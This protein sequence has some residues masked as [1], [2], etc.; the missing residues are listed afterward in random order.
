MVEVADIRDPESFRAWLEETRQPQQ[1][2]VAL[3]ARAAAR[4]L[5][6]VWAILAR[7]NTFS[8]LPFVRANLIANVAGL[9]PTGMMTDS[10]YVSALRGS[11]YAAYAVADDAA[12]A[13][14][15]DAVFPAR[16]AAYA[17]F[18][19]TAADAAFAATAAFAY[20]D[21]AA[22]AAAWSVLRSDCM[23]V[24]EGT[25]LRS[26]PLFPDRASAPL[27]IAWREVQRHYGSDAAWHF[28][29]DWYRRFLTGRRQNWPLLLE[30][31]LQDND[32]WHGSDAEINA[33]IAEIAARFEAEDPVD[34]PQGDSIATALPQAIENSYNAERIVERDDRFDVEP[35]TEIDA[36]AFQLGLQR[37]TIL[38]EDIA[39][40]VADRP[41][42]LSALPEAIR[43]LVKALAETGEFPYLVYHAL[44]RSA[45]RIKIMCQ[46]EELP[47]NDYAVEDFR[48]Q[49]RSIALDILANDPQVKKA[50]DARIDFHLEE[51]TAAEQAD[52]RKLGK[53]LAEV[54]VP[55]LGDQMVEDSETATNPDEPDAQARR[56]AFFQF[57]SRFFRMLDR[58]RSKVDAIAIAVGA[59]GIVVTIIGMFA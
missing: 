54:S 31:A 38:L 20:A 48:Q 36:D 47:S 7:N 29:L 17:V 46:R 51:L 25:P 13:V 33:R 9:A 24:T 55:R 6:A 28:W 15:Y 16:A 1:I 42:P 57:A 58:N 26:A 59:G 52:M 10:G 21:A 19:A 11:A 3:A 4:V 44:L 2:R 49:L 5:P 50:L 40:A 45:H 34:P 30:I 27:A 43:P 39:E 12:Y 23:A 14:A 35:I 8:S 37:A 22:T 56:G 18:A 32:F 41:Q 53:G